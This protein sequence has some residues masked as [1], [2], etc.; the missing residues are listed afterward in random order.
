MLL[1][2]ARGHPVATKTRAGAQLARHVHPGP[3]LAPAVLRVPSLGLRASSAADPRA[4]AL[5]GLRRMS[6]RNP[7][8][9]ET[10]EGEG[11]QFKTG[12]RPHF[13]KERSSGPTVGGPF[14]PFASAWESVRG[15]F[16]FSRDTMPPPGSFKTETPT[17]DADIKAVPGYEKPIAYAILI[18]AAGGVAYLVYQEVKSMLGV[19]DDGS[20]AH[21]RIYKA[22]IGEHALPKQTPPERP[23]LVI[24]MDGTLTT[25]TWSRRY[26]WQTYKRPGVEAFINQAAALGY[27]L[28]LYSTSEFNS[29]DSMMQHLDPHQIIEHRLYRQSC[30][31][32][33]FG[34]KTIEAVNRDPARTIFIDISRDAVDVPENVV[35]VPS[36]DTRADDTALIDL[37]PFLEAVANEKVADVRLAIAKVGAEN[38]AQNLRA[39]QRE[40]L[41]KSRSGE[42]RQTGLSAAVGGARPGEGLRY[43]NDLDKL[44]SKAAAQTARKSILVSGSTSAARKAAPSA[45]ELAPSH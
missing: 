45:S 17:G 15:S 16:G 38:T 31:L 10:K 27:E 23:T 33:P 19:E 9:E 4:F 1:R 42:E 26:G 35:V 11:F 13:K 22:S 14:A 2:L 20:E 28:V 36:Y 41:R 37:L 24:N 39:M 25:V 6:T 18:L 3:H 8:G 32:K 30:L 40:Y 29:V 21:S 7:Y 12:K 44:Q 5:A 34:M 43:F